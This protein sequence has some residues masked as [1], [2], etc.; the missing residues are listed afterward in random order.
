M[1]DPPSSDRVRR[2]FLRQAEACA[3]LGSPFT[4]RLCRLA[5]ERLD[6]GASPV[7]AM[8]LGWSGDPT[9]AGDAVALRF[10]GALHALVLAGDAALSAAWP[11]H[12]DA[13]DDGRLWRAVRTATRRHE[14]ALLNTLESPPQT[15]EVRRSSALA[16]GLLVLARLV[17]LPVVLSEV[18]ASAGLN[19]LVDRYRHVLGSLVAGDAA[20]PLDLAPEWRGPPPPGAV[21]RVAGRAGCDLRPAD[22]S[23]PGDRRRLLSYVWPDQTD[24]LARTRTALSIAA[25]ER[26]AVER[27]DAV[28]WLADR[29]AAP[30]PGRVHVVAHTIAWQYLPADRQAAGGRIFADAGARA[31]SDAPLAR[32]AMEHDGDPDGAALTLDL[33]P[34]GDRLALGRVDFHTRWIDWAGV[35]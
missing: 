19:L 6:A 25:E 22:P 10:A 32:L 17:P 1:S 28:D 21:L 11:P 34:G 4:A 23:D 7:D 33:W 27:A 16:A 12:H 30:M 31:T 9:A 26:V 15:N 13:T 24:R 8:L 14:A 20:S 5:A 18:G 29:L 35:G 2:S 3:R